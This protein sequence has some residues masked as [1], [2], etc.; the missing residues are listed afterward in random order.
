MG[1]RTPGAAERALTT[2]GARQSRKFFSLPMEAKMLAPH[3][4][5]PHINRGGCPA[6]L[7]PTVRAPC[8]D[9]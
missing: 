9:C 2:A 1:E 5:V 3:P 8:A 4:G 6:S 7:V